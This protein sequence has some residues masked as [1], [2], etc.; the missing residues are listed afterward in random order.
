MT[1]NKLPKSIK[2]FIR[3]EKAKI[4]HEVLD[5]QKR[6]ELVKELYNKFTNEG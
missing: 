3:L 2:K 1:K 6:E 4:R 5:P